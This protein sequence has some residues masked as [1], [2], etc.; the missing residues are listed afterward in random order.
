M[1]DQFAIYRY[2]GPNESRQSRSTAIDDTTALWA[3]RMCVGEGG[4]RCNKKKAAAMM[5]ALMNR[6]MLHPARRFWPSY[7]YLMRRFSQPI[8]P[9]WQKGGDLARTFAGTKH[10][11]PARLRR[12]AYISDLGWEDI[13]EQIF[14]SVKSFQSGTL[15]PPAELSELE[16]PR[17]SNWASYKGLELKY[18]WGI[19]FERSRQPDW[20]FED[21][22][23]IKG[24]VVLDFWG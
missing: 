6:W 5:W 21:V 9:R 11:T 24:S 19:S 16:K 12:R 13:P 17:I 22:R 23:L 18:P 8:N 20:F 2:W 3:A 4:K 10:C 14:E 1:T 15:H 7:L